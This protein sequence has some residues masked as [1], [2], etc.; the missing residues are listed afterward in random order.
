[1]QA[2]W[3][4][5]CGQLGGLV[6]AGLCCRVDGFLPWCLCANRMVWLSHLGCVP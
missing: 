4:L 5:L 6:W 2:L 3:G 1:M